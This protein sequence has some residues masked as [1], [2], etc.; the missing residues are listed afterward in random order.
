[1]VEPR[2]YFKSLAVS[3]LLTGTH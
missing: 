3:I 1:M 2:Q